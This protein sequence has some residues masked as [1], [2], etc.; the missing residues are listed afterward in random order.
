MQIQEGGGCGVDMRM[1][2]AMK[3]EKRFQKFDLI[4]TLKCDRNIEMWFIW[5]EFM[6]PFIMIDLLTKCIR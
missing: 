5:N 4:C 6:L 1:P 2:L 3:V